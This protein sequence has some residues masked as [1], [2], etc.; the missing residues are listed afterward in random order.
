M[1]VNRLPQA[2]FIFK[3]KSEIINEK[4]LQF[5]WQYQY[6][7]RGELKTIDGSTL[8]IIS[9]GILNTN[10]GPDFL[11]ARIRIEN[12]VLAGTIELHCQTS[13][14][15]LH[16]HDADKNYN[17][18][19]LHVVFINDCDPGGLHLPLLELEPRISNLL[20]EKYAFLMH[21]QQRIH[22]TQS[23]REVNEL[24]WV[25]WK[26]TLVAERLERKSNAF[27]HH[28]NSTKYNWSEVLWRLLAR[29]FGI[30]VNSDAF[31]AIAI[32]L[33]LN[34]LARHKLQIHQLEA[35][36]LG[37]ANLLN[38]AFKESYP[39][40]LAREYAF[41][42]KKYALVPISHPVHFLRMRP[43]NF[44]SIRLAQLAMLLHERSDLL[45]IILNAKET[46]VL[47]SVFSVQ[48][49]DYWLYHYVPGE[50]SSYKKKNL[51]KDTIENIIINTVVPFLYAYGNYHRQE[52]YVSR[53]FSLFLELEPEQNTITRMF[54]KA[55]V[56]NDNAF[57]SQAL[58]EL[59]TQYCDQ[60][61]CL[62][63]AIG[64]QLIKKGVT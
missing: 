51:G 49:N 28:L 8:E 50:A 31:E 52:A 25:K 21:D 60:K 32:S 53:A 58:N 36:L 46:S 18:V 23:I 20:I 10:Q 39:I 16:G 54:T 27:Q 59:M 40:M 26:E 35:L 11:D 19:I 12:T 37:Q 3:N 41:L 61:K 55:G 17:N 14:W 48:P 4:L 45:E 64:Y 1:K 29:N 7:N 34:I 33:P 62:E 6:F 2:E 42:K 22:C 9:P 43:G 44:P 47:K 13:E 57:H 30:R 38:R 56:N 63:C 15:E 24:V 5:I